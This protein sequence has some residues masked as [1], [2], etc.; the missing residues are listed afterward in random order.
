MTQS[1]T[2]FGTITSDGTLEL[3]GP[4]LLTPGPVLVMIEPLVET[5]PSGDAGGRPAKDQ[6]PPY[7]HP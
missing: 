5:E 7:D 4:V 2:M 1:V 3:E 6:S